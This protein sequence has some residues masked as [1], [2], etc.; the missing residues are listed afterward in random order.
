MSTRARSDGYDRVVAVRVR[1]RVRARQ[2]VCGRAV[3]LG[4]LERGAEQLLALLG[5]L[6]VRGHVAVGGARRVGRAR[7]YARLPRVRLHLGRCAPETI[8][9]N[10]HTH[11]FRFPTPTS[12]LLRSE[13]EEC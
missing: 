4:L 9:T 8:L 5:Q 6:R 13:I 7:A 10:K 3:L 1:D 12:E 2:R 11:T